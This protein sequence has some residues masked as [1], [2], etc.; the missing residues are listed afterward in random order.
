MAWLVF[1]FLLCGI[2]LVQYYYG[3]RTMIPVF[4]LPKRY[5][6]HRPYVRRRDIETGIVDG[7]EVV[8]LPQSLCLCQPLHLYLH[9]Y[10]TP[11]GT[12]ADGGWPPT[13]AVGC[14]R[15]RLAVTDGG[16]L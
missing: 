15:R 3:P 16:W 14:N 4:L 5:D 13:T 12:T 6:Y 10:C 1:Y 9:S 7:D 11:T 2:L 8:V